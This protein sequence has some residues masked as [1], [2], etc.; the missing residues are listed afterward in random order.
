[1][2]VWDRVFQVQGRQGSGQCGHSTYACSGAVAHVCR[3]LA[4][5]LAPCSSACHPYHLQCPHHPHLAKRCQ[6]GP[7]GQIIW[8]QHLG[9]LVPL[10]RPTHF[11]MAYLAPLPS[12]GPHSPPASPAA[13]PTFVPDRNPL[14]SSKPSPPSCASKPSAHSSAASA[15]PYQLSPVS[16]YYKAPLI[17]LTKRFP[18]VPPDRLPTAPPQAPPACQGSRGSGA[19]GCGTP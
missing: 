3:P 2:P 1:M 19:G 18:P 5:A 4:Q 12:L 7:E 13:V 17:P 6:P 8:P 9:S 11:E 10:R 14:K 16:S 15:W